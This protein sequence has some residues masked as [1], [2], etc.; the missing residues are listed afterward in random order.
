MYDSGT[1]SIFVGNDPAKLG[2]WLQTFREEAV[3]AYSSKSR[4][5]TLPHVDPTRYCL[6]TSGTNYSVTWRLLPEG[7]V[8]CLH[9]SDKL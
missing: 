3:V 2:N 8:Y 9:R 1:V 4:R 6:E 5:N 7:R